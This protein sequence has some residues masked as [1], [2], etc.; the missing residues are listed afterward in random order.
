MFTSFVE[1]EG[2]FI[3]EGVCIESNTVCPPSSAIAEALYGP[4]FDRLVLAGTDE[5]VLTVQARQAPDAVRVAWNQVLN[6]YI[7]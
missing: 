6:Y 5:R 2:T 3:N 7:I 1:V 4:E